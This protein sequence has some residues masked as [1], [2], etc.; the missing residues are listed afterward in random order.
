MEL[1][2]KT[3]K[4]FKNY[5]NGDS[6]R[7]KRIH[8]DFSSHTFLSVK[9]QLDKF[10]TEDVEFITEIPFPDTHRNFHSVKRFSKGNELDF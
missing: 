8:K 1:N 3:D 7:V 6:P 9:A 10:L 4:V 2:K 5:E